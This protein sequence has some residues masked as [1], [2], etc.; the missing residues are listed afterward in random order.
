MLKPIDKVPIFPLLSQ[1]SD[2][3]YRFHDLLGTVALTT[4]LAA[5]QEAFSKEKLLDQQPIDLWLRK[6]LSDMLLN[7][8][9]KNPMMLRLS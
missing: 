5:T 2:P 4:Q 3:F 1:A 6:K 9:F 8:P 7:K